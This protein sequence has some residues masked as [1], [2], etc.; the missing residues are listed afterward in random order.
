MLRSTNHQT[1]YWQNRKI[2]WKEAYQSTVNHPHRKLISSILRTIPFTSLWEVG[3]GGGANLVRITLDLKGKQLGGSDVNADAIALCNETF[4]GGLFHVE[5]GD[6]LMM[7]DKS[8]DVIL[9]DMCLIYV[10]PLKIDAYLKEFKRVGRSYIVLCEFH[11][12]SWWKRQLARL[13]GYHIYD[14]QKRLEKLGYFN[15]QVQHIPT[16]LWPG[17]DKNTEFRS[18][19]T[20]RV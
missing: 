19:I 3:C 1:K 16:E 2:D 6:N 17:T 5:S 18:I 12:K 7:S 9:S 13:G 14:Y 11:S 20:A 4:K 15:I 8:V 10:D